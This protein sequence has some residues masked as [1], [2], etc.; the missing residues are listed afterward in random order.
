M[1]DESK[2]EKAALRGQEELSEY[3]FD[4][5]EIYF[6]DLGLSPA[7]L[8]DKDILDVGAGSGDFARACEKLGLRAKITSLDPLD[9]RLFSK[10]R[11]SK[12]SLESEKKIV[13]GMGES[14]PFKTESFDLVIS[15]AAVPILIFPKTKE[16]IGR[17][18]KEMI[19]VVR[20]GGE[21][22]FC[23]A[24]VYQVN[25]NGERLEEGKLFEYNKIVQELL[26][27]LKRDGFEVEIKSLRVIFEPNTDINIE[28][29]TA[30][31]KKPALKKAIPNEKF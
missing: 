31:I 14:L 11:T 8:Q 9:P 28:R 19:R 5:F 30:I 6:E 2:F 3:E 13:M 16:N 22:R 18:I 1:N 12:T 25:K 10:S 26:E 23:P 21:V 24:A 15:S 4:V 7:E 27:K 17:A 29:T 20:P